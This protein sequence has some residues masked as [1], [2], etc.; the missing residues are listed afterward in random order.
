MCPN[1]NCGYENYNNVNFC[2][3]CGTK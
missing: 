2:G 3:V 1:L